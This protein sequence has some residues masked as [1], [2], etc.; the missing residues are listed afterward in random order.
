M[1][2]EGGGTKCQ[3]E[4]EPD[5]RAKAQEQ[6][7]GREPAPH[8][9][10]N[11]IGRNRMD[12]FWE[13]VEQ[14][15]IFTGFIASLLVGACVYLWVTGQEVPQELYTALTTVIAFFFGSKAQRVAASNRKSEKAK[16]EYIT[17]EVWS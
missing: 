7:V 15:V 6:D 14:S 5:Q 3:E 13:L 4:T 12:K 10:R 11:N 8:L 1:A 9:K 17:P 16:V 2:Q